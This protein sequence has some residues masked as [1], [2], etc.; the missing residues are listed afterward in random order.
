[1]PTSTSYVT[2][3][4]PACPYPQ[5]MT[6]AAA[7][8][9]ANAG[10]L[11]PDCTITITDGPTIGTAGHTSPTEIELNPVNSTDIGMSARVHTTFYTEAW[12]AIYDI[13]LGTN[14][15]IQRMTDNWDN[16]AQDSDADAP[17]VH[18]Q[19]PW[20]LGGNNFRDNSFDD[21]VL[22]GWGALTASVTVRDNV[23][24]ESTVNLTGVTSGSFS[25]NVV[26]ASSVTS[27][28][29]TSNIIDNVLNEAT[30]NV[31]KTTGTFGLHNNTMLTGSITADA[32]STVGLFSLFNNVFGGAS[33][34]YRIELL[35]KTGTTCTLS[36]NRF[37]NQSGLAYDMRFSGSGDV[38]IYANEF[39]AGSVLVNSSGIFELGYNSLTDVTLGHGAFT[40]VKLLRTVAVSSTVTLSGTSIIEGGQLT[41]TTLSS[42]GFNMDTFDITGGTKTLTA[43]QSDRVR[44]ALGSNLV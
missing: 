15:S 35:G 6:R 9:L 2:P 21:S 24:T 29:P 7:I 25:G 10:G 3:S 20:H 18:T 30:V 38:T 1:M 27:S 36:G 23:L 11:R 19:I 34:G 26:N 37:F 32:A 41:K 33:G 12:D 13:R 17:T 22:T 31:A 39:S 4:A 14:G 43:N 44:N 40:T 5:R 16:T 8:A 28:A 42:G